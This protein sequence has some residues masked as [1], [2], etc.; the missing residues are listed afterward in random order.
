M[1]HPPRSSTIIYDWVFDNSWHFFNYT[2]HSLRGELLASEV[3]LVI[4]ND[5]HTTP[6]TPTPPSEPCGYNGTPNI[7]LDA[8]CLGTTPESC[9]GGVTA[10]KGPGVH[11]LPLPYRTLH[12]PYHPS[13]GQHDGEGWDS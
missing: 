5:E 7:G 3:M 1:L 8:W 6:Y 11:H 12:L 10:R 4:R 2:A 13:P 9:C